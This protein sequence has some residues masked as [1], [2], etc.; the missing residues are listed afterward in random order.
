MKQTRTTNQCFR[1]GTLQPVGDDT[2]WPSQHHPGH[3]LYSSFSKEIVLQKLCCIA[4]ALVCQQLVGLLRTPASS[5]RGFVPIIYSHN[6]FYSL[7]MILALLMFSEEWYKFCMT[8]QKEDA[9]DGITFLG[10]EIGKNLPLLSIHLIVYLLCP[11][12]S[13]TECCS[14]ILYHLWLL[15]CL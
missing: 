8:P 7:T 13:V 1:E 4:P 5:V 12:I 10:K 2:H 6:F 15:N 3:V 9:E 14:W 11:A